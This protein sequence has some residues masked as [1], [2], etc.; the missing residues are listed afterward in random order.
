MGLSL[1]IVDF[2]LQATDNINSK[3]KIDQKR[4]SV[5]LLLM[6]ISSNDHGQN[7]EL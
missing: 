2:V 7:T 6:L 1:Q 4:E 5:V 3:K